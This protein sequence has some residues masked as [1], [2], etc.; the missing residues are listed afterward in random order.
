VAR[1]GMHAWL[2]RSIT[3]A[4]ARQAVLPVC[5]HASAVADTHVSAEQGSEPG[6]RG[7]ASLVSGWGAVE[8][9]EEGE[10]GGRGAGAVT[11]AEFDSNAAVCAG[12]SEVEPTHTVVCACVVVGVGVGVVLWFP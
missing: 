4:P 8:D 9:W 6:A 7:A 1:N 12:G 5:C 2:A 11:G 3:P 10:E